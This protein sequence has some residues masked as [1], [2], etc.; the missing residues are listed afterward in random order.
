MGMRV[1]NQRQNY[2]I[3]IPLLLL[4]PPPAPE[5]EAQREATEVP[6]RFSSWAAARFSGAGYKA[7]RALALNQKDHRKV[8]CMVAFTGLRGLRVRC[9]REE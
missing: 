6:C 2:L 8:D 1:G 7:W 9:G 5:E 4:C 3:I